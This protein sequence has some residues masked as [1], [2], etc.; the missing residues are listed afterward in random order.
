MTKFF[1]TTIFC[2][3]ASATA[4]GHFVFVV[5]AGDGAWAAVLLS[6]T[7]LVDPEVNPELVSPTRLWVRSNGQDIALTLQQTAEAYGVQVP[8]SGTRTIH[9]ITDL[10][11]TTQGADGQPNVLVYYPKAIVGDPFDPATLVGRTAVVELVPV[12][13]AGGVRLKLLTRGQPAANAEVTVLLPGG[14]ERK[15]KT[16]ATGLTEVFTRSGQFGAWARFWEDT[17]G[18]RGDETYDQVRHYATLVFAIPS[19]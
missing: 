13:S 3:V 15:A 11:V 4:L 6:E 12:R 5:P 10:G 16:D 2:A 7:L 14:A 19:G 17:P 9:G 1:V 18:Q 8:G